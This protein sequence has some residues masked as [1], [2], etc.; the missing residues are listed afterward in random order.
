MTFQ[1]RSWAVQRAGWMVMAATVAAALAG[2]L[3]S[4]PLAGARALSAD[5]IEASYSR[6]TRRSLPSTLELRFTPRSTLSTVALSAVWARR[7]G[8]E[9]I[10]PEPESAVSSGG[11]LLLTLRTVP[12]SPALVLVETRGESAGLLDGWVRLDGGD[13]LPF[14]QLVLP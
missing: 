6:L 9:R 11:E 5:G 8:L 14:R 7:A 12:G 10:V 3:G 4:G 1:R 13:P 2:L